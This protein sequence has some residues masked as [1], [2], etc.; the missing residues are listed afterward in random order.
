MKILLANLN[1]LLKDFIKSFL[2]E[3]DKSCKYF[4]RFYEELYQ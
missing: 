2:N 3:Y 1:T 4:T